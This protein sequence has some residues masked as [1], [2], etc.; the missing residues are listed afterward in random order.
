MIRL[1]YLNQ[2]YLLHHVDSYRALFLSN[3]EAIIKKLTNA[4]NYYI[5]IYVTHP[6][7]NTHTPRKSM[8]EIPTI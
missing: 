6:F 8:V 1:K 3:T 4:Q 5:G 2:N 7:H